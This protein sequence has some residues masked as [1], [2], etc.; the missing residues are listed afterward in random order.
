MSAEN[1]GGR[2]SRGS[3]PRDKPLNLPIVIS[4]IAFKNFKALRAVRLEL[5][6]FNLV[7]GPNGSGKSSLI[8]AILRLRTLARL[9]L[10]DPPSET[11]RPESATELTFRFAPPYDGLE[12]TVGCVSDQVCDSLQVA[13]LPRGEGASD[14]PGLRSRL[15]TVRAYA[16]DPA[17]IARPTRAGAGHELAADGGNLV[18]YLAALAQRDPA[19]YAGWEAELRRIFPEY[20]GFLP[21]PDRGTFAL[22]PADPA[23]GDDRPI[24]ADEL[25]Q[26]T[27]HALALL[28]LA[29]DPSP[30][31]VVCLEELDRGIHPRLLRDL[32]DALYRLSHPADRGIDRSP[33]QV[34]ATTH[35]PHLLDLFRDH[36]EEVVIAEK[37]GR[38]ARLT[39]LSD[40]PGLADLLSE[41]GS[42]GDLWYAGVLGGVPEGP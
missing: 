39:R 20:A 36:P 27:L 13:P 42:L 22:L 35:S 18:N 40:R 9:P 26:G 2:N 31:A 8:E 29:H 38:T 34:I 11:E 24:P 3:P 5:G 15:T 6:A 33:S 14:W 16:F 37:T 19:A 32:R 10:G 41:G 21:R 4:A 25:S 12:A 30:P 1:C 17:A 7:V 28:A 23:P